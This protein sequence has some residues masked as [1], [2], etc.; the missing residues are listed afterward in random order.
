MRRPSATI[1]AAVVSGVSVLALIV[2][3]FLI[4]AASNADLRHTLDDNQA[5]MAVLVDQYA[6]LYAQ[7]QAEGVNPDAPEPEDVAES[8]PT[9][10]VGERGPAGPGPSASEVLFA[11]TAYCDSRGN[12]RGPAG[13]PGPGG[14]KGE[15]GEP[16]PTGQT[17]ADGATGARGPQ[18]EQGRPPT[19]EEIAAAVAAYCGT[20]ACT[21]PKGDTGATGADGP[22]PTAEQIASAVATYCSNNGCGTAA[23][24]PPETGSPNP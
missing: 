11:V 4:M 24:P 14:A 12:C 22:G 19:A 13:S 7:A 1:L 21:G 3:G 23:P 2:G 17:G 6:D 8:L 18:G 10:A 16:G 5:A 20:G 9:P 15:P